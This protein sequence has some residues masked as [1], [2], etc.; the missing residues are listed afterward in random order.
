MLGDEDTIA[1]ISTAK[2]VGA[3]SIVRISGPHTRPILNKCFKKIENFESHKVY[4]G[5]WVDNRTDT[6]IDEVLL[7][8]FSP[9]RGFT[10]EEAAEIICHGGLQ[11]TDLVLQ[12]ALH[13]GARLARPGEFTYRAVMNEKIDLTQAEAIL[14]MINARTPLAAAQALR[15]LRGALS[16]KL[17]FCESE[18]VFLLA[19]L[20][21]SIDFTTEDIQPVKYNEMKDRL[22]KII[23]LTESLIGTF[24]PAKVVSQGLRIVLAG[25]PNAGKS[26]LLNAL[27]GMNR[28]IVHHEPG[29]TRDTVEADVIVGGCLLRIVDTA[30][31]RESAETVEALGVDRSRSEVQTADMVVFVVDSSLGMTNEDSDEIKK[32]PRDRIIINFNKSDLRKISAK[33]ELERFGFV[34]YDFVK[35]DSL[36]TEGSSSLRERLERAGASRSMSSEMTKISTVRQL[37]SLEKSL[38]SSKEAAQLL[39]ANDSPDLISFSLREALTQFQE[40]LGKT[41][42]DD[43]MHRV[44]SE[45]CLG[46]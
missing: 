39:E 14:E 13:A 2:G 8:Y 28:S 31:L 22:D 45:F 17:E 9:G 27:L 16:E 6:P 30:G 23:A 11:V 44:F 35:T 7:L 41:Y 19:N 42:E 25:R 20:E 38:I 26:S 32:V 46:K 33:E 24:I 4:H 12:G 43:I 34:D 29:T 5:L 21:A 1:A 15:N 10:G 40:L 36:S 18:L 37:E 3:L